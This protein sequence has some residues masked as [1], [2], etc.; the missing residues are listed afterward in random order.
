MTITKGP[1]KGVR[2]L[3]LTQAHA[4]P[5][6]TLLLGD[7]GAEIIKV[8]PPTGDML[9]MGKK[10][11]ETS[12]YYSIAL[13]RNKKS[14]V[15]NLGS[16]H[17]KKAFYDLV[18]ISDAVISNNRGGV[19]E[20]QGTDF[21]TL[22]KINPGI[23]RCNISGYGETGP[24]RDF[25]SYDIIAC[26]HSGILSLSGEKGRP[27]VIP[28]GIALADMAGGI[29]GAF[30]V[31]AALVKRNRD[32][33]GMKI[34]TNLLDCLLLLQQTMFQRYYLTGNAPGQQ[35]NK[36]FLAFPYGIYATKDGYMTIGP[37]D[38]DKVLKIAGL[39][40]ML[41]DKKFKDA[42]SRC[43][44]GDEF[45]KKFQDALLNKTSDE[46]IKLFRDENDIACG[47]VENY[48]QVV[49]DPQV[50]HNNMIWEMELHEE[51]YKTVG[52]IFK[53]P[54]VLEGDPT[55]PPDLGEHTEKILKDL[56]GYSDKQIKEILT[57]NEKTLPELKK[58]LK[59]VS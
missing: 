34:E 30:S 41:H 32:G 11:V 18:K 9:R 8:E 48:D 50:L 39:D 20:R 52:S 43:L 47:P 4:G 25:P 17:G 37:S 28:G 58:R 40:W 2:I 35:G 1:L 7:L 3:D 33:E 15:L 24:Y 21:E 10:K 55:H 16:E 31:L 29:F 59:S 53:F 56:L 49:N 51:K 13:S 57:E 19:P 14:I 46:W 42:D 5:F 22:K 23:V 36:H 27:P 44:N 6:G 38:S 54:G 26:G 45:N 12:L